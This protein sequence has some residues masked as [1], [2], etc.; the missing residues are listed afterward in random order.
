ML[1]EPTMEKLYAMKLNGMA[2]AWDEQRQQPYS[3]DLCFY[4]RLGMLVERQWIWKENR[5]LV[6]SSTGAVWNAGQLQGDMIQPWGRGIC[7]QPRAMHQRHS[8]TTHEVYTLP[9]RT[10][11]EFRPKARGARTW[12]P[13]SKPRIDQ[14]LET[15]ARGP[16]L[17]AGSGLRPFGA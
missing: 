6:R 7:R 15:P 5:A 13:P 8:W 9:T 17:A 12:D 3:A 16:G 11:C 2:D 14:R 10:R 1:P 4:D